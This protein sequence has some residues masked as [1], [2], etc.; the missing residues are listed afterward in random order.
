MRLFKYDTGQPLTWWGRDRE[1]GED[2]STG[3]A[4]LFLSSSSLEP[5]AQALG[6]H[7]C[8]QSCRLFATPWIV[9][10]QASLSI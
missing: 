8:A 10:P 6:T 7:V 3:N 9:A 1:E 4:G 2:A 5:E